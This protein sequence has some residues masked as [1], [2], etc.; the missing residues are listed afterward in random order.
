MT[1][2]SLTASTRINLLD[3]KKTTALFDLT[4]QRLGTGKRVN[5]PTDNV[6]AFFLAKS[7]TDRAGDLLAVKDNIGLGLS[8]I[9]AALSGIDAL[10]DIIGQM[11]AAAM[12]AIDQPAA[13]RAEQAA[14]F[15][16]LRVQ[17]DGIATDLTFDGLNLLAGLP[18]NLTVSFDADTGS[19]FTISG[20]ASDSAA[21][22]IGSAASD[23]NLFSTDAYIQAAMDVLDSALVTLRSTAAELGS[24]AGVLNTR[25]DY[26]QGLVDTLAAGA[27][28]LI[29]A[30]LNE[31]AANMLA[32]NVARELSNASLN[33]ANQSQR[34]IL[35]LF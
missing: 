7:L 29:G 26:T 34:S 30:D 3:A 2:I 35:Q 27:G 28:D 14:Q 32:L 10:T 23:F 33:I 1:D 12:N 25:L 19:L 18:D 22:G 11:I 20:V 8:T 4:A 21:L 15:D 13:A 5:G 6:R 16:E 31:E 17:M 24:S 9:G